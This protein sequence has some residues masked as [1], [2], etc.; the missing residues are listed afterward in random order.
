MT[1]AEFLPVRPRRA[2]AGRRH[3]HHKQLPYRIGE[4]VPGAVS[5]LLVPIATGG[6]ELEFVA[7]VYGRDGAR[8]PLAD[9]ASLA[10][11][12]LLQGAFT[13]PWSESQTW[14]ADTNRLTTTTALLDATGGHRNA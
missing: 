1:V 6:P 3:R 9:G 12:S 14:R 11:A 7:V 10:L 13:A 4:V 5:V 2:S 8:L